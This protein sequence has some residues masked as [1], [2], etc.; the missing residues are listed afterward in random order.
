MNLLKSKKQDAVL[1]PED[2]RLPL[3]RTYVY[4][5]Q[6]IMTMYGGVIAV[7]LIIGGAADSPAPKSAYSSQ[8]HCS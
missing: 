5:I 4:G 7:P 2:E 1:R 8:R 3:G 6:H